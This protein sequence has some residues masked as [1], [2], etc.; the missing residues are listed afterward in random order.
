MEHVEP[1]SSVPDWVIEH[2]TLLP[3]LERLEIDYACGGKSLAA[4]C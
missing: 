4:A 3:M 1:E 2:P